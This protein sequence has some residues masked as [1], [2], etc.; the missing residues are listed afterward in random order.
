LS[1]NETLSDDLSQDV[2]KYLGR[3]R[4]SAS[5]GSFADFSTNV[6]DG[7]EEFE[8]DMEKIKLTETVKDFVFRAKGDA[9]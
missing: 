9:K 4:M 1:G 6:A 5:I 2:A 3:N 7:A 8:I